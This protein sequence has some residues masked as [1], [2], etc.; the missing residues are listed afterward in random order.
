MYNNCEICNNKG[1]LF[2][3]EGNR[4]LCRCVQHKNWDE[5]LRPIIGL[6]SSPSKDKRKISKLTNCNQVITKS[7][8]NIAGLIKI[9]LSEWF[10]EDYVITTIE[11][12]NAIGFERHS[13]FKSIHEFASKYKYFIVDMTIINTLRAKSPG[14]NNNDIMC[15]LDLVKTVMSTC[16]KIVIIIKPGISEF[17]KYYQEL[18]NG[19]NDF[20]IEYFHAGKYKKFT[21]DSDL[22]EK[23]NG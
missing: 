12:L 7:S 15:L 1:Y 11:E 5:Y 20:G 23:L 19:L 9:M 21:T 17:T 10:S 14:W 13:I 6:I 22:G 16:Q 3:S 18:C 2:N 4:T 8:E